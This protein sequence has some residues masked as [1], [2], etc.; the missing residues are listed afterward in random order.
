MRWNVLKLAAVA[1]CFALQGFAQSPRPG[2]PLFQILP[3]PTH[4]RAVPANRVP[5]PQVTYDASNLG[6]PLILDKGWR[7]GITANPA[8]ANP[9]F[10]DT[11]WAVRDAQD[12]FADVPDEDHPADAPDHDDQHRPPP[13]GLG[14]SSVW[15][16]MHINLAP[17]HGPLALLV[18]L[19]VPENASMSI[20]SS[21]P[22]VVVFANGRQI[23]PEGPHGDAPQHYQQISRMYPLN[24]PANETSLVL[25]LRTV[26]I[27]FG[28]STY[29]AFFAGRTFHLG[30]REDLDHRLELWS[31]HSLFQRIPRVV[32]SILLVVLAL[33]L[34]ALYFTQKGHVEYL[35][36]ALHE[37]VQ[38]PIGF[39]EL[40]GSSA[41]MDTLWYAATVLQLV[42]I[43]AYLYF[44][45]LVA[46][47]SLRRRWN[48]KKVRYPV[49]AL[50]YTS[51]ILLGVGP[52]L[53]LVGH[54][55]V[56]GIFLAVIYILSFFWL[57][58][59][60][61]FVFV[62]L[63]IATLRRNFE[64]GLLLIP[65]VLSIVGIAE[66]IITSAKSA[67]GNRAYSNPLTLHAGP[68]PIHFTSIADFTSILAIVIII[69]GRFLRVQRD[70]ERASSELAAARSVQELMIPQERVQTPGFEVDSVY[71]PANEVGGDFFHIQP[72][73][74]GGL[75][76]IIGDVAGKGLKAA[77]NVS[78][79]M[80]GLRR[81]PE[82]SPA[83]ILESLNRVLTGSESFTTCQVAW[84]GADG[85][86]VLANAGHLPP[87]LNSQ[88]ISL[89]GGLPLGVLP[90]VS[91]EEVRLY[92]HPGDR[93]LL[94][95]DGVVEARQ[96]S[97]ELFGFDRVHNLTGQSAFYI[98]DAAKAFGQEDDITILTI[99]R[100]AQAMAA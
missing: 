49:N 61:V 50:R 6:S 24:V 30:H 65:L 8:A 85:E 16:R 17:A 83:K 60:A 19:P 71:N 69:F 91:Y 59:W 55:G 90:D 98:A 28:Y 96:P 11:A 89:P 7:V 86:V 15:F 29:T 94:M 58:G 45:F 14:K 1:V 63:I 73:E 78:M 67:M 48:L 66:P 80:G 64:A 56:V 75:L 3:P 76:V 2:H 44:E 36:L 25:V 92:L 31:T 10:D 46:F 53:L 77:M 41:R 52:V 54:N 39:I 26:Y 33:F 32:N 100:L 57:V 87:Y 81:T 38:A 72:T 18:E 21:G 9:D 99:R 97:G 82:R 47:L 88:E 43:S 27:K 12:A 35:L 42:V 93:M 74:D 23:Q 51:P 68:I 13:P 40:A 5:T 95:S 79:I 37:M 4:A 20:S 34:L 62:T 84:F 22:A 70:Q